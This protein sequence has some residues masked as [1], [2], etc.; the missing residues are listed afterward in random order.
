MKP[1]ALVGRCQMLMDFQ[2]K[3]RWLAT[4]M[5]WWSA[6]RLARPAHSTQTVDIKLKRIERTISV[7]T[8]T[9]DLACIEQ[10]FVHRQYESPY[11]LNPKVI[12]D[13]GANI[14]AASL[15]F[16]Q[17]YPEAK[18]YAIEPEP[19]NFALLRRNCEGLGNILCLHAALWPVA[20]V[21]AFVDPAA[22]KWAMSLRQ[23]SAGE[24]GIGSITI[25]QLIDR[26]AIKNIDILK[27]DI[28]GGERELFGA[29]ADKWLDHVDT[30][31]IELHDWFKSGCAQ[32]FYKSLYGRNFT[33]EIRGENIF[34][35]FT[36]GCTDA[37][38]SG[39]IVQ[40][41]RNQTF[42]GLT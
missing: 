8:G 25:P 38:L 40:Q 20:T 28:E 18:I 13:A 30:I 32:S 34:I 24:E 10:V 35:R 17:I 7:R 2:R 1:R 6:F 21:L 36:S 26:Y 3:V 9:S 41:D 22:R 29:G 11:A 12:V 42:I 39:P 23:A 19:S 37:P 27:V 31:I 5:P 15:Y 33:Q 4:I 16:S 14:G